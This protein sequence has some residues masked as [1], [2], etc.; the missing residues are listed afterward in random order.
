MFG[1]IGRLNNANNFC[2]CVGYDRNSM[3]E[4]PQN[5][6]SKGSFA[7]HK[8]LIPILYSFIHTNNILL[9]LN[10]HVLSQRREVP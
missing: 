1:W 2:L 4:N 10:I 8:L 3:K 6:L 5:L 9:S 7:H